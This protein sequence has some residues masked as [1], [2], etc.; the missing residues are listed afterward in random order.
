MILRR[1]STSSFVRCA[2]L[3][4]PLA[5]L[6]A[7][8]AERDARS[9]PPPDSAVHADAA[10]GGK[11]SDDKPD[12]QEKIERKEHELAC[13]RLELQVAQQVTAADERDAKM[14]VV[15]CERKLEMA[16]RDVENFKSVE[17]VLA[18]TEANLHIDEA[19]ERLDESKQELKELEKS[20][21]H[22][23][24]AEITKEL[25]LSRGKVRVELAQ[26]GLELSQKK[27][28]AVR[29]VEQPKKVAELSLAREKAEHDANEARSKTERLA[30]ENKLKLMKAE[31][32]VQEIEHALAKL[33]SSPAPK[34]ATPDS[35]TAS[36]DAKAAKS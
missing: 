23:K 35:K 36:S 31:Q 34:A 24:F 32:S 9:T 18:N 25:V 4:A 7:C 19:K 1:R 20:Y 13:A 2:F 5:F 33:Q 17:S 14:R 22:E 21:E 3:A 26:K 27:A 12:K 28:S 11:D 15:E 16:T 6:A 8:A 29:D 30:S 10:Q